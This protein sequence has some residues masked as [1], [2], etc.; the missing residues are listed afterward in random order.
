LL[1]SW[2]QLYPNA[3]FKAEKAAKKFRCCYNLH[4]K[5]FSGLNNSNRPNN[6]YKTKV[7]KMINR[8]KPIIGL[9]LIKYEQTSG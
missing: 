5:L 7:S 4:F 9:N 3:N 1:T 2:D 8:P 6:V